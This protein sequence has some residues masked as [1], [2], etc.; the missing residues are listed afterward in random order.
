MS[1]QNQIKLPW[2]MV[3]SGQVVVEHDSQG[4][5]P[6][7]IPTLGLKLKVNGVEQRQNV[8]V[9]KD[10]TIELESLAEVQDG[11]WSLIVSPDDLTARVCVVPRVVVSRAIPNL[12]PAPHLV[13]TTVENRTSSSPLTMDELAQVLRQKGVTFGL[14]VSSYA[15]LVTAMEKKE[16]IVAEGIPPVPGTHADVQVYF[17]TQTKS[18]KEIEEEGEINFR[19]RFEFTAVE[20]GQVLVKRTPPLPG[21]PGTGVYGAPVFPPEPRDVELVP[22]QGVILQEWSNQL[23]ATKAGRPVLRRAG[24]IARVDVMPDLMIKGNVDLGTGNVSF[25]GDVVIAGD[26]TA[27]CSVYAGGVIKVS[28]L[29]EQAVLQACGSVSVVGNIISSQVSA[30]VSPMFLKTV[31]PVLENVQEMLQQLLSAYPQL[32]ERIPENRKAMLPQLLT[33]LVAQKTP[34]LYDRVAFLKKEFIK[35]SPRLLEVVGGKVVD[36]F[37]DLLRE[38]DMGLKSDAVLLKLQKQV[39]EVNEKL[40]TNEI[41][42]AHGVAKN[43]INSSL[44]ASGNIT[45]VGGGCYN[46]RLLAGGKILINGVFRGGELRAGDNVSIKEL[47]SESGV[48]TLV[49]CPSTSVVSIAKAHENTAV[50]IGAQRHTFDATQYGVIIRLVNGTLMIKN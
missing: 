36:A 16:V 6:T 27:G 2:A 5:Y 8:S 28:G 39:V 35:L 10:D 40:S 12:D 34:D 45:I 1:V 44:T 4:P 49:F 11:H 13:I 41:V 46:S 17:D 32:K 47:G 26:V 24:S 25:V 15:E 23:V 7:L 43:I 20:Q 29:V 42:Q 21:R 9:R 30:G 37:T 18:L 19:E 3:R 38:V 33:S 50:I 31:N 48:L 22:G 14:N